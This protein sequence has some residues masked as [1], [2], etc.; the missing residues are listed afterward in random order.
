MVMK[1]NNIVE[2]M[3]LLINECLMNYIYLCTISLV[4]VIEISV[5]KG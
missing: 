1:T 3:S 4:V 5:Y 2:I